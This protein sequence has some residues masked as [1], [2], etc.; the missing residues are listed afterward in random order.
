M[1]LLECRGLYCSMCLVHLVLFYSTQDHFRGAVP[2]TT[3]STLAR[4]LLSS[5]LKRSQSPSIIRSISLCTLRSL[6]AA[7]AI[8]VVV[9]IAYA[10]T[11]WIQ[12]LTTLALRCTEM[13]GFLSQLKA[14]HASLI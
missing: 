14:I 8:S 10:K 7:L 4:A 2:L 9:S 12:V 3:S 13:S 6:L 5:F 11:G 1:L